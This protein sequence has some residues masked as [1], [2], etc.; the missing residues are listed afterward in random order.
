MNFPK[1]MPFGIS[2]SRARRI[3]KK[4]D[5][6]IST[7][8]TYLKAIAYIDSEDDNLIA[9]TGFAVL[10]PA[11]QIYPKFLYYLISNQKVIDTISSLS[12]GVSYPAINSSDLGLIPVWFP[13][14][15][16]EQKDI[17][18]FIEREIGRIR[19]LIIK[20]EKEIELLQE[21][22]TALISEAVTGKIDVRNAAS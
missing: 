11:N 5:T 22:R 3:I 12:V 1:I 17:L 14:S 21:Y 7:V 9:S 6:I 18:N 10:T 15:I 20:T 8:R 4:G 2:P 19:N 16:E 13:E